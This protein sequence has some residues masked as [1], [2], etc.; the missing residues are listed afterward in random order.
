MDR[1]KLSNVERWL[2]SASGTRLTEQDYRYK[3]KRF[4]EYYNINAETIINKWK[5]VKY[6]DWRDRE[7]FVDK[8]NERLQ[9]YY[10]S[11]SGYTSLS[12]K[13]LVSPIISFLKF[14]G[15]NAKIS[16]EKYTCVK[17]G[18]RAITKEEIKRILEHSNLRD[19]TFYLMALETGLRPNTLVQLQYKHIKEDFEKDI[20]P[21][22]I[23]V[24]AM[25]VK[26]KVG[27]RISFIGEDGF[28]SLKEYLS[29]RLPLKDNDYLFAPLKPLRTKD[30][31][32]L[33]RN[34]FTNQFSKQVIRLGIEK[35][36]EKLKPKKI[37]LYSLRK[38]FRNNIGLDRSVREY[39]MGHSLGTDAFYIDRTNIDKYRK[40]YADA[41]PKIRI[42]EHIPTEVKEFKDKLETAK[43]EIKTLKKQVEQLKSQQHKDEI[44]LEEFGRMVEEVNRMVKVSMKT[45]KE[46][47]KLKE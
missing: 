17:Y 3:L 21:M 46:K 2:K 38:Y 40:M 25:I 28:K 13:G 47:E 6:E 45:T 33:K 20:I 30:T 18:N 35:Q 12:R 11:L 29:P 5:K 7:K 34:T 14:Y 16:K 8:L 31:P 32:Y 1:E 43:E 23:N 4:C 19:R 15:I 42:Y 9:D 26:D 44:Y 24:P 36:R 22:A 37:S 27:D 10:L 39:F 41:Y